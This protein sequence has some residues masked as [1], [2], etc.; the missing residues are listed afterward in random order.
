MRSARQGAIPSELGWLIDELDSLSSRLSTLEAPSGEALGNTVAKL[1][2]LV[3]NIQ[4]QLDAWTANRWTNAQITEQINAAV[5]TRL[6]QDQVDQRVYAIVGSILSGN[7]S[8]GG[9]LVVN[10]AVRLPGARNTSVA[11]A[12]GRVAAWM[13]GDGRLGNTA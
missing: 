7:V 9:E 11:T 2:A 1:S 13:A 8:I 10:G 5:D 3:A 12:S 6:T 4:Q